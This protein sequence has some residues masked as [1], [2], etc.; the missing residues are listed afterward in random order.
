MPPSMK[1]LHGV[2]DEL[3]AGLPSS[4][5]GADQMF[6]PTDRQGWEEYFVMQLMEDDLVAR[7]LQRARNNR[8]ELGGYDLQAC[9]KAAQAHRRG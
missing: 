9:G 6:S 3:G 4:V 8:S 7:L 1:H 2:L 5:T